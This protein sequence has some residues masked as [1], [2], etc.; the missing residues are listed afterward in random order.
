MM[1]SL[2]SVQS[3]ACTVLHLCFDMTIAF[4]WRV[5]YFGYFF[6]DAFGCVIHLYLAFSQHFVVKFTIGNIREYEVDCDC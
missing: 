6:R 4:R 5:C 1:I 3:G 2:V